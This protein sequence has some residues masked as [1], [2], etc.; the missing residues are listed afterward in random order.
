MVRCP[1]YLD[2]MHHIQI[3]GVCDIIYDYLI[4][5]LYVDLPH[6]VTRKSYFR[7]MFAYQCGYALIYFYHCVPNNSYALAIRT[8]DGLHMN[9]ESFAPRYRQMLFDNALSNRFKQPAHLFWQPQRRDTFKA[10]V[11]D[12]MDQIH[13][14]FNPEHVH[15]V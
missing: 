11:M 10:E 7:Y 8:H 4:E 5:T 14:V 13:R 12:V 1:C 2:V 9:R 6:E 15:R 3:P